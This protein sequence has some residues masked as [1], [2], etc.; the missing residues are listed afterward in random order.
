MEN[1]EF[2]HFLIT[3]NES[4]IIV[5]LQSNTFN[6]LYEV[7]KHY[8]EVEVIEKAMPGVWRVYC[9]STAPIEWDSFDTVM[10][11]EDH[12]PKRIMYINNKKKL[13]CIAQEEME[14]QMLFCLRLVR[15]LTRWQEY[16]NRSLFIHGGLLDINSMGVG[17]IGNKKAGKTSTIL[18]TLNYKGVNFST[19]DDISVYYDNNQFVANGWPRSIGVRTDTLYTL[20]EFAPQYLNH[21]EELEHPGNQPLDANPDMVYF[22][23]HELARLNN[24]IVKEK[25]SLDFIVFPQ[26]LDYGDQR[27]PYI[28]KLN[29]DQIYLK[30]KEN[31]QLAPD[32]HDT[33][34]RKYFNVPSTEELE[35]NLMLI[36]KVTPAISM[37]Q[38]FKDLKMGSKLLISHISNYYNELSISKKQDEI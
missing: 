34:L 7:I 4:K 13:I 28:E 20:K 11:Q 14:W 2:K 30:L 25:L 35:K 31:L 9:D 29:S 5:T 19:N 37:Y 22:H 18:A 36:S 23:P 16:E 38:S 26:F 15:N 1:N 24:G 12:E 6:K 10:D 21:I 32:Y 3:R 8:F 17:I 33:F 27:A